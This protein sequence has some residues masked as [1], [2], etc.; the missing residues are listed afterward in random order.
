MSTLT[1][2]SPGPPAVPPAARKPLF[3]YQIGYSHMRSIVASD[4][5]AARAAITAAY[6]YSSG[7]RITIIPWRDN[8]TASP[9]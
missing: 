5:E 7:Q 2:I 9:R 8:R 4:E 6:P 1:A 3:W